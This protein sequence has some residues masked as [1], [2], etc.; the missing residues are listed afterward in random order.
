MIT[1]SGYGIHFKEGPKSYNARSISSDCLESA[2]TIIQDEQTK[3][4]HYQFKNS[5][6]N[7]IIST[8]DFENFNVDEYF[9]FV[10]IYKKNSNEK[11]DLLN[12]NPI[13]IEQKLALIEVIESKYSS[14]LNLNSALDE[15]ES[16]NAYKLKKLQTLMKNFNLNNKITR[17]N[18]EEFS[19]DFF[20]ILKGPPISLLD[21]FT[22]TKTIRMNQRMLRVLEE[23]ML[24]HGLKGTLKQIPEKN[25]TSQ[26]ED[27]SYFIKKIMKYKLWKYLVIPYDL[28]WIEKIKISDDLL[29]KILTDGLDAHKNEVMLEL[30]NQNAIDNY[31]RLRKV[32]RPVAFGVGFYFMYTKYN[33]TKKEQFINDFEKL[34]K[35]LNSQDTE[36]KTEEQLKEMQFERVLNSFKTHY[37]RD[38]TSEEYKK[39]QT[40]I[41]GR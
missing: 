7:K 9:H 19:S 23:D 29:E 16:L 31:E 15:I 21:Y 10:E 35:L 24:V 12:M 30:K 18:L 2:T 39:I 26:L 34:K 1:L 20:L 25:T 11:I 6:W 41:Y 27:S 13:S 14:F 8:Q 5:I 38:P 28:P 3:L 37:H 22:K 33:N 32:Y 36:E 17:E 40:K 4:K